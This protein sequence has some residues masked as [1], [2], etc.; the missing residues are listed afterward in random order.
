MNA[1]DWLSAYAEELGSKPP[2]PAELDT[3]LALA[4]TAAHASERIAAPVACWMAARAGVAP[5][6]AL[7]LARKLGAEPE[8][9]EQPAAP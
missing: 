8:K 3:L 1:E 4:G 6:D 7:T 9:A 5:D 2:T